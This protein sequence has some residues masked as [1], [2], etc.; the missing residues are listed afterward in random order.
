MVNCPPCFVT[1]FVEVEVDTWTGEVE[2]TRAVCAVD[3]AP[4]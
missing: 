3:A 1:N 2:V 4:W